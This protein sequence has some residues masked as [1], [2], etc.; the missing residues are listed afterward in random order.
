MI[1]E[2]N[3]KTNYPVTD[4]KG[5]VLVCIISN[6]FHIS[7]DIENVGNGNCAII[8]QTGNAKYAGTSADCRYDFCFFIIRKRID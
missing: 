3:T 6:E 5:I 2:E 8:I 7:V 1:D 4:I